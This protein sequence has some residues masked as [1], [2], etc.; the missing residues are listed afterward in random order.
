MKSPIIAA[1][2]CAALAAPAP[3]IAT[4]DTAAAFRKLFTIINSPF[5]PNTGTLS[6]WYGRTDGARTK[7]SL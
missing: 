5:R 2:L 3:K 6:L 7:H 4:A 1:V